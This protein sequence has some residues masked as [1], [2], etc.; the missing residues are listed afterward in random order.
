[1]PTLSITNFS[2]INSNINPLELP[3]GNIIQALNVT[4]QP[5]GAL[6]KRPGYNTFLG[7]PDNSSIMSLFSWWRNDGTTLELY[8]ASGSALYSSAQ[9]TGAWTLT[10]NGTISNGAH[11]GHAVLNDVLIGGEGRTATH[12]LHGEGDAVA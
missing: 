12:G 1:M 11:F 8:R 7:T 3:D 2:G 4:S 5:F 6:T 9:G 10:G